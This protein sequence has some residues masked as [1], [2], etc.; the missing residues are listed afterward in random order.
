MGPLLQA[1]CPQA[2]QR[3]SRNDRAKSSFKDRSPGVPNVSS[4]EHWFCRVFTKELYD[5][6]FLGISELNK[7]K[8][9]SDAGLLSAFNILMY[10][11]CL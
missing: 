5:D 11:I 7:P 8:M 3:L 2:C 4:M 9:L 1:P 6:F 10:I